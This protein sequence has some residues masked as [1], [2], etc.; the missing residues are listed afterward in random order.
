MRK[1]YRST[2]DRMLFGV[3]GGLAEYFGVEAT[4]LRILLV[5]IAVFSAGSIV[6]VYLVAALIIPKKPHYLDYG[7]PYGPGPHPGHG[8]PGWHHGPATP[9]PYTGGQNP[10]W[11]AGSGSWNGS[12]SGPGTPNAAGQPPRA[13]SP[14]D[15]M[16]D[17]IE[18]KAL[19]REI[20]ELKARLAQFEKQEK[21]DKQEKG[22]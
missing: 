21:S 3:C 19:R 18:K 8:G 4:L 1:L 6:F 16:M 7:G 12:W 20:E 5:V 14:I 2:H 22:E 9:P 15:A 11:S 13:G 10:N 17:D